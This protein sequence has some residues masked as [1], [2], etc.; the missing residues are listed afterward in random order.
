MNVIRRIAVYCGSSSGNNPE[1]SNIAYQV[2][3][4]L[5]EN[6]IGVVY[7]GA[8]IGLMGQV[9]SGALASGG[10]VI[11]VLPKFLKTK[12]IEHPNLTELLYVD[13]MQERKLKMF[14]L[15]DAFVA[16][17]GGFGTMEEFFE[18]L[19]WSQL[20]LHNKPIGLLNLYSFYDPLILQFQTM[21]QSGFLKQTHR[22]LLICED[23]FPNL[24][25]QIQNYFPPNKDKWLSESG[26]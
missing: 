5:T 9:A 26:I 25:Q 23:S 7:G 22:D 10:S 11:G 16:L 20:G 19:T 8:Q 2:G 15:A 24:L 3:K 12:E 13:T 1:F 6:Q 17:P 14:E 18:I 4:T 21:F